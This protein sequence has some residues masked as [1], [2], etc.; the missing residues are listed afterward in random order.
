MNQAALH[1]ENGDCYTQKWRVGALV[2]TYFPDYKKLARLLSALQHSVEVVLIINNGSDALEHRSFLE[3]YVHNPTY[4]FI[5]A[6]HNL[7]VATALNKG[8]QHLENIGCSYCWTFDQDSFPQD[9]AFEHLVH[10]MRAEH[11][12]AAPIAAVAP[13][14]FNRS[15]NTPLPFLVCEADGKIKPVKVER[16]REVMAAITS[17][18]LVNISI[19]K[20]LGGA[21]EELFIDHVDTEWCIRAKAKGFRIIAVPQAKLQHELGS[22]S[23]SSFGRRRVSLT[24]RPSIRTYYMLRNGWAISKMSYAPE[25]WRR[26]NCTQSF[27]IILVAVFFGPCRI[28]QIAAMFRAGCDANKVL[29][30]NAGPCIQKEN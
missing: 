11:G 15:A 21:Y 6:T 5:D 2:V 4:L 7:G 24:L 3:A 29:S 13:S 9:D 25:G 19:W 17:G 8:I 30:E 1:L 28:K 10:V 16:P 18:M 14:V 12:C 27:K 22:P 23:Y 26:Y 20:H